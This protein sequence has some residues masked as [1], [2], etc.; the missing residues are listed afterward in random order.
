MYIPLDENKFCIRVSQTEAA[1]DVCTVSCL[2]SQEPN[3]NANAVTAH[4][5]STSLDLPFGPRLQLSTRKATIMIHW[6]LQRLLRDSLSP[7]A[8]SSTHGKFAIAYALDRAQ[9]KCDRR[10][11]QQNPVIFFILPV[12][13]HP[14]EYYGADCKGCT[15]IRRSTSFALQLGHR[16]L[17][18]FV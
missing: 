18:S 16:H 4:L 15:C 5:V 6:R 1:S 17:A 8:T 11:R 2:L 13:F 10:R 12:W 9:A 3:L 14:F 7:N